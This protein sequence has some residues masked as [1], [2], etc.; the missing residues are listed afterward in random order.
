MKKMLT[1]LAVVGLFVFSGCS[2]DDKDEIFDTTNYVFEVNKVDFGNNGEG[3]TGRFDYALL[4]KDVLLVYR[5]GG[6]APNGRDIW[7]QLPEAHYYD[8]GTI[9]NYKFDFTQDDFKI[10]LDGLG[11][12]NIPNDMRYNQTFRIVIVPEV[13]ST[14]VYAKK[15][16]TKNEY[17]DYYEVIR[18]YNLDDS[19]VKTLN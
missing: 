17:S 4:P 19:N 8:N 14:G 9:F 11:L 16:N 13:E 1:L 5:L 12:N 7:V 3:I 6:V 15:A 2:D 18:K 10:Y